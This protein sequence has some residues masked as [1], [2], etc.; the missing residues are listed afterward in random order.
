MAVSRFS[1][2]TLSGFTVHCLI[3]FSRHATAPFARLASRIPKHAGSFDQAAL[4][5]DPRPLLG[6]TAA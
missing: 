5:L 6:F 1:G 2:R 4:W 3:G